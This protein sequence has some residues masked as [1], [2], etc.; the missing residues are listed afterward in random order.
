MVVWCGVMWCVWWCGVV[1]CFENQVVDGEIAHIID[2]EHNQLTDPSNNN[3]ARNSSNPTPPVFRTR[4]PSLNSS[5]YNNTNLE[6]SLGDDASPTA[7]NKLTQSKQSNP[8]NNSSRSRLTGNRKSIH[9]DIKET[10]HLLSNNTNANPSTLAFLTQSLK[11]HSKSSP[12]ASFSNSTP[13]T[14]TFLLVVFQ[15]LISIC[16]SSLSAILPTFLSAKLDLPLPTA[17][18]ITNGGVALTCVFALLGAVM[19]DTRWGRYNTILRSMLIATLGT[20]AGVDLLV[21]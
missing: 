11:S 15:T 21:D 5:S 4:S 20:W 1:L 3:N 9:N 12:F 19:S 16:S 2:D 17:N 7:N 18:S 6:L 10:S 14:S 8:S 13:N